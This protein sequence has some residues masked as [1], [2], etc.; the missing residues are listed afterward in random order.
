MS[1][2]ERIEDAEAEKINEF[3]ELEAFAGKYCKKQLENLFTYDIAS[4]GA[5]DSTAANNAHLCKN[6]LLYVLQHVM[7]FQGPEIVTPHFDENNTITQES[8]LF[9]QEYKNHQKAIIAKYE[10]VVAEEEANARKATN[11]A[12]AMEEESLGRAPP[13][14]KGNI[15]HYF[16]R[17]GTG[18]RRRRHRRKTVRNGKY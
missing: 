1:S 16:S 18:G 3:Q 5:Q 7:S 9:V 2:V 11:A 13:L 17:A 10:A 8:Q 15:R 14:P 12:K 6:N 4:K